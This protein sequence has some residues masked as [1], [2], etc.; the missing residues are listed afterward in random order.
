MAV[1]FILT[2]NVR[3][4]HI[5]ER[6]GY[7]IYC[8]IPITFPEATLGA[9]IVVPTLEGDIKYTIPEGTQTGTVFTVKG[10]GIQKLNSR[11]RSDRGEKGD[12]R[13]TVTLEVPRS[14]TEKQK[15]L[16]REF[17]ESCDKKNYSKKEE[18]FN[19]IFGSR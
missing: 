11:G 12:L 5:F 9:E 2:V 15:Q 8:E 17:S 6:D 4:H 1:V 18:F 16:L 3:P 13:F 7:D 14:L 19:K 10:K